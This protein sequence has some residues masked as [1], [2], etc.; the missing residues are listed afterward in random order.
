MP[1]P[2]VPQN[3]VWHAGN[4]RQRESHRKSALLPMQL[5]S[6]N[7]IMSSCFSTDV[8]LGNIASMGWRREIHATDVILPSWQR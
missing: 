8:V 2:H 6:V 3:L 4:I 5:L 7:G 1:Y